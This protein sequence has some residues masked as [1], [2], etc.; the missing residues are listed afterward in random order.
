MMS[1]WLIDMNGRYQMGLRP[2]LPRQP[3]VAPFFTIFLLME[4]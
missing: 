4:R 3:H 2:A 1:L